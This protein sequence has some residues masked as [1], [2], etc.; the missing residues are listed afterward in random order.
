METKQT[1]INKLLTCLPIHLT[2]YSP[3]FLSFITCQHSHI[4]FPAF[5]SNPCKI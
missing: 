4:P 5:V 1:F 3:K 2:I